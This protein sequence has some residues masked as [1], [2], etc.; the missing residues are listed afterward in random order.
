MKPEFFFTNVSDTFSKGDNLRES[1]AIFFEK[2][3][4]NYF[5]FH[6]IHEFMQPSRDACLLV[7]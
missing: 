5:K 6:R 2:A 7:D 1:E 3:E 4:K